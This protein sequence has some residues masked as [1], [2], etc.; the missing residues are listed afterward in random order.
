MVEFGCSVGSVGG[1]G[2]AWAGEPAGSA[3]GDA[4]DWSNAGSAASSCWSWTSMAGV[5]LSVSSGGPGA[6]DG[7]GLGSSSWD[8]WSLYVVIWLELSMV[9]GSVLIRVRHVHASLMVEQEKAEGARN[10]TFQCG[11]NE[12][13]SWIR[14]A[15]AVC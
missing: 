10:W 7:D 6:G 5:G 14:R 13:R 8:G 4:E 2:G 1:V 15:V 3:V 12:V 11:A 9:I